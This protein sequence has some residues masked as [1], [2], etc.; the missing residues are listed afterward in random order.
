MDLEKISLLNDAIDSKNIYYLRSQ[1]V[2]NGLLTKEIRESAWPLLLKVSKKSWRGDDFMNID[3]D[4]IKKDI[5][6]SLFGIDTTDN[7]NTEEREKK[8]LELSEII[9]SIIK[10]NPDLRYFQGFNQIC[11]VFYLAGGIDLGFHMSEQCAKDMLRDSMRTSFEDGLIQQLNLIYQV[12]EHADVLVARKLQSLYTYDTEIGLPS[13][14]VPWVICWLSGSLN[15]YLS[16]A[17]IFDFCLATHPLAPVYISAV[18]IKSK[19][20]LLLECE[21]S[22][23]IHVLY[24]DINDI[25]VNKVCK[26][27]FELMIQ[28]SPEDLA[29]KN[30]KSFLTE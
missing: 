8:R 28:V 5:E 26:E 12:L 21:D 11:T 27:A 3:T 25:N 23:D 6:R 24:R 7:Y 29:L 18:I 2:S 13:I 15:K 20:K 16:I 30:S 22:S 4:I 1:A 10:K 9:N 17:R 19:K 14:A